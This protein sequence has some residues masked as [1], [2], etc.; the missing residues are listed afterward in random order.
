MDGADG[1]EPGIEF[2]RQDPGEPYRP[3]GGVC[4]LSVDGV[5]LGAVPAERNGRGPVSRL[6]AV[7]EARRGNGISVSVVIPAKNEAEN[8]GW[9]LERLPPVVDEVVLVDGDSEDGTPDVAKRLRPDI[10]VIGQDTPGKGA[11]VRAGFAAAHGDFIVMIDADGSMDPREIVRCVEAL[12]DRRSVNGGGA[13]EAYPIIKGSRFAAGGGTDDMGVVRRLG[14]RGLLTLVNVLYGA[15]LTDLC[16]GLFAFRRDQ[17]E[18]L[19]LEADGF[20]IET[21]ITVRALKA[22]IELGEVPS[23]EAERRYGVS[24]LQTWRDGMRVLRTLL[25]ERWMPGAWRVVRRAHP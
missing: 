9:V 23:F 13:R 3:S 4:L 7:R 21:E 20:E 8:I 17:L 15:R 11:A 6:R 25:R 22:G 24:N 16:Y 10:R 2:H 1:G 18:L 19:R 5:T 12:E 14:N